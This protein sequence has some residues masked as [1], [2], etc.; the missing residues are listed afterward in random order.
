M[1]YLFHLTDITGFW[2][3]YERCGVYCAVEPLVPLIALVLF[4]V[5][6]LVYGRISYRCGPVVGRRIRWALLLPAL[7]FGLPFLY[8]LGMAAVWPRCLGDGPGRSAALEDL[9]RTGALALLALQVMSGLPA[10][11][12][13]SGHRLGA[14]LFA[15]ITGFLGFWFTLYISFPFYFG[16]CA[17]LSR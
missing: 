1:N 2:S 14:S 12:V 10:V 13:A 3:Q 7:V 4:V 15:V 9:I 8:E 5:A 16:D 6:M 11:L 17:T